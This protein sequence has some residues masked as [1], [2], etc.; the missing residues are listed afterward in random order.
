MH[1]L[2]IEIPTFHDHLCVY[3]LAIVSFALLIVFCVTL[4]KKANSEKKVIYHHIEN[5]PRENIDEVDNHE[6]EEIRDC[7]NKTNSY[8]LTN[9]EMNQIVFDKIMLEIKSDE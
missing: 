7:K 3:L 8:Q 9:K 2:N 6:Y 4:R 1:M 5:V